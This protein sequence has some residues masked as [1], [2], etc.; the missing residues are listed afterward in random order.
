MRKRLQALV[1]K[2]RI[3]SGASL[4]EYS[5]ILFLVSIVAVLVL[6]GIGGSTNKMISSVN[7]GFGP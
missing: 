4:V 6:Q 7:N 2:I 3:R 5:L 1:R